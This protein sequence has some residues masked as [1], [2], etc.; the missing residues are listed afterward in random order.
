MV[1]LDMRYLL[2]LISILSF[3]AHA[4]DL[5][6]RIV[7]VHDGDTVTLLDSANQQ[8]KIRLKAIDAPES[9]QAFGQKSKTNL[10]AI[11]FNR[12][13]VAECGK[14]DKYRRDVCVIKVDGKDANEAQVAA[15]MAWWYRDAR[16]QTTQQRAD[17]EAAEFNAKIR[18][19]GLWADKNPV[20]PWELWMR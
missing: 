4:A 5:Q 20:P 10:A 12:E 11:L 7:S 8:H 17:Y 16:E 9:H 13:V 14:Q 6:G 2:A 19:L 18:R 15:G 1:A 3:S